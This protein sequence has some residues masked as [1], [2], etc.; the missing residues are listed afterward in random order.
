MVSLKLIFVVTR[1]KHSVFQKYI[2]SVKLSKN[3]LFYFNLLIFFLSSELAQP[4]SQ[5]FIRLL[6]LAFVAISGLIMPYLDTGLKTKS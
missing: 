1:N 3:K 6:D 2:F 5:S 4:D